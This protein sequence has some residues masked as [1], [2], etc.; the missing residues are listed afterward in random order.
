MDDETISRR[1]LVGRTALG[2]AAV[3]AGGW[4]APL[5]GR[6]ATRVAASPVTVTLWGWWDIRMK[7]YR[8][9]AADFMKANPD[10]TIKVVTFAGGATMQA[11]MYSALAAGTGPTMLK[12]SPDYFSLRDRS[13]LVPY[14]TDMFPDSWFHEHYPGFDLATYGRYVLPQGSMPAIL[15][16]NKRMFAAAGITRPPRTWDELITAAK[17]LTQRDAKGKIAVSG[18]VP[19]T[20]Q[21][22][23]MDL[24]YQLGGRIAQHQTGR[25]VATFNTPQMAKVYQFLTDLVLTHKVWAPDFLASEQAMGT[26]KAAMTLCESYQIGD[27]QNYYSPKIFRDLAF[28]APPTPS[29]GS[30]PSY[31]HKKTV[32][33]VSVLTGRPSDETAAAFRF[34]AY[35]QNKRLD[36]QF[37]HVALNTIAPLRK[38]LQTYPQVVSSPS[39]RFMATLPPREHDPIQELDALIQ[40]LNDVETQILVNKDTIP[41]ALLY[42]QSKVQGLLDKK[43]ANYL[44]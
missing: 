29:G 37:R 30:Q 26:G 11:K 34:I 42:G 6:A 7:I 25:S 8:D 40:I 13:L 19:G 27:W 20:D 44:Q 24:L 18:F 41:A 36:I 3:A 38:E 22:A 9:A 2:A 23:Q 39:L 5:T 15:A 21:F 12:M 17:K 33:D 28:A 14:P 16:Y 32:M 1:A 43:L 4:A 31:G 10:V 35:I